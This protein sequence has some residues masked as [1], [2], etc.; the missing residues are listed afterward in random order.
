MAASHPS[1]LANAQCTSRRDR[2]A[3][4]EGC[5]DLDETKKAERNVLHDFGDA[6]Q[7]FETWANGSRLSGS[8]PPDLTTAHATLAKRR[9]NTSPSHK[10]R[11]GKHSHMDSS[12][13][14]HASALST[15][16]KQMSRLSHGSVAI[17]RSSCK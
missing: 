12:L 17:C 9:A 1:A 3:Y 11:Y 7:L 8:A 10:V 16:D 15:F 6:C 2:G 5:A 4:L 14:M 13:Q